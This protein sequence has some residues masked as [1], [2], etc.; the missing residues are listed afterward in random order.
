MNSIFLDATNNLFS[1]ASGMDPVKLM[2]AIAHGADVTAIS[3]A[4]DNGTALHVAAT[5]GHLGIYIINTKT[6]NPDE[7]SI[8]EKVTR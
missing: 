1:A 5:K 6:K 4:H 8:C 3:P 7:F 2:K